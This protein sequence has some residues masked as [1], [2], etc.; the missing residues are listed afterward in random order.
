MIQFPFKCIK[1]KNSEL[2]KKILAG[3][4]KH[5]K[6]VGVVYC[7]EAPWQKSI[8]QVGCGRLQLGTRARK[9]LLHYFRFPYVLRQVEGTLSYWRV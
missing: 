1:V 6:N 4:H 2:I 9:A 7:S 8:R 3:V 5:G